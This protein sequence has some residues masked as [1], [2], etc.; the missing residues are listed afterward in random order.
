MDLHD[1]YTLLHGAPLS[2]G[3]GGGGWCVDAGYLALIVDSAIM[4]GVSEAEARSVYELWLFS[5]PPNT[6]HRG[7]KY[8]WDSVRHYVKA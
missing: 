5:K 3:P 4:E 8:D 1:F 2:K 7:V 6:L